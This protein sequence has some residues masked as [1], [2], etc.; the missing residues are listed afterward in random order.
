MTEINCVDEWLPL[1]D[2][3]DRMG[4]EVGYARQLV[5]DRTVVGAKQGPRGIFSVPAKFLVPAVSANPANILKQDEVGGP[6]APE[7]VVSSLP[8]TISLL[9]DNGLSDTEIIRWLFEIDSTLGC[10]PI[11]ALRQGHKSEVRR[12]AQVL[13]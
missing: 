13:A 8:G 3:A 1:P 6:D 5:R 7:V 2:L 11:D 9:T 12:T 4:T 10:Q